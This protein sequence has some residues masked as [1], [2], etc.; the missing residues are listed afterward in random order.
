MDKALLDKLSEI[1]EEEMR[2]KSGEKLDISAYSG[3]DSGIVDSKKLLKTGSLITVRPNTRFTSFPRHKHNYIEM[4]YVLKGK[5]THIIE[6]ENKI[7]LHEGGLLMMNQHVYHE[8]EYSSQN[9]IAVN[10]IILPE[11]FDTAIEMAG[12]KSIIAEFI[13]SGLS[14]ESRSIDYIYFDIKDDVPVKNLIENLMW[15][16]VFKKGSRRIDQITM[17]LLIMS[18]MRSPKLSVTGKN[19]TSAESTAMLALKEIDENYKFASL[20]SVAEKNHVSAAYVSKAVKLATGKTFKELLCDKRLKRAAELLKT[21]R[22][23]VDEIIRYVGYENSSY[24]YKAFFEKYKMTP[25][26]YRLGS[27]VK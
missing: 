25:K 16:A 12:N 26:S 19:A 1:T 15:S 2:L 4:V 10:F 18:L 9:D 24:F 17:G 6:N 20:S 27:K 11:F 21:S 3:N 22:L 8:T 5:Q 13:F 7:V 23:T 14:S